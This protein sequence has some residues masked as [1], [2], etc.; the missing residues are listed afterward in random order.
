MMTVE[1][2]VYFKEHYIRYETMENKISRWYRIH[3]NYVRYISLTFK[4]KHLSEKEVLGDRG[5]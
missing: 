2:G 4:S 3:G 1:H 5:G